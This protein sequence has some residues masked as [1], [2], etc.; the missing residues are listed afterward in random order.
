M[1]Y[2]PLFFDLEGRTAIV[3]GGGED[4]LRKVRL[5]SKTPA[6]IVVVADK[7]HPELAANPRVEWLARSFEPALLD[8]AALVI[9]AEAALNE[10]VAEAAKVRN[11]PVNAVDRADLST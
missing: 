10:T 8:G 1:R 2:F 9:S 6:R 5:L 4:G 7:L 11:I 3:V